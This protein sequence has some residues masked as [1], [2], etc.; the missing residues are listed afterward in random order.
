M[1]TFDPKPDAPVEVRGELGSIPSIIPGVRVGEIFPRIAQLLNRVTVLRSLHHAYPVHGTAFATSGV[2]STDIPMES[3]PR[4]SRHWPFIGSVVDY[5]GERA[6]RNR[7]QCRE[8]SAYHSAS[9]RSV[10]PLAPGRSVAF[11]ARLTIPSGPSFVRRAFAK[12]FAIPV[13]PIR[14]K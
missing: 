5:L 11:S 8:I 6:M 13:T 10:A 9:A 14:S 12:C 4:D 7:L 2:P 1:D 3:N